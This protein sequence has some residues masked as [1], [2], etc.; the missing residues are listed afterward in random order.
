VETELATDRP[1]S[2]ARS[3][4]SLRPSRVALLRQRPWHWHRAQYAEK[5]FGIFKVLQAAR[6]ESELGKG[7]TSYFPLPKS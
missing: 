5:L 6:Q 7:A 1:G 4:K 2:R 3:R